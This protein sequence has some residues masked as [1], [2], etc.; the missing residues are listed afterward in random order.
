MPVLN[1]GTNGRPPTRQLSRRTM[2]KQPPTPQLLRR[3]SS[4]W[5]RLPKTS[6]RLKMKW[7]Q[8]TIFD[9][10]RRLNNVEFVDTIR[11]N[12]PQLKVHRAFGIQILRQ[13]DRASIWFAYHLRRGAQ[14]L[15]QI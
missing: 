7:N 5:R 11:I 3:I 6:H 4:E 10:L 15:G 9:G 12:V 2:K 1:T 14:W 13:E 8:K